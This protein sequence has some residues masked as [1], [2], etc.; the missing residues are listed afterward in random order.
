M[1]TTP[2]VTKTLNVALE[3]H[4]LVNVKAATEGWPLGELTDALILTGLN[5]MAE[6][7]QLLA[8]R[9]KKAQQQETE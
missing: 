2:R 9:T 4:Q 7:N 1:K 8:D 3:V 6:T 5:H